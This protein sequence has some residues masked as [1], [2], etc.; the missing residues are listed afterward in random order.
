M[1]A[2]S[3]PPGR[4]LAAALASNP[5]LPFSCPSQT[6]SLFM[7]FPKP[8]PDGTMPKEATKD[9][10]V[11]RRSVGLSEGAT[12]LAPRGSPPTHPLVQFALQPYTGPLKYG[13]IAGWLTL[14][15]VQLG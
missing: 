13:A 9:V 6:P 12:G 3:L 1:A 4:R 8:K 10:Q 15:S 14:A 5:S 2:R 11:R 7:S